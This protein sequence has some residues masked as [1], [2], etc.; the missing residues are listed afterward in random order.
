[1]LSV[2]G[3]RD[4]DALRGRAATVRASSSC[5][6]GCGSI[7]LVGD[8]DPTDLAAPPVVIVEGDV[9]A[10]NGDV[11]GGLLLFAYEGAPHNLEVYAVVDEPLQLPSV[12]HARLRLSGTGT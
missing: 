4:A 7:Y 9:L 3:L 12:D 11:I 10:E 8:R 1:M 5:S 2:E 6:C